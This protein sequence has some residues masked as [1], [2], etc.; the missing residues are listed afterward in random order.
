MNKVI[1]INDKIKPFNKTINIDGDKSLSIRFAILASL[2]EGKSRAFNLLKSED[3][4]NTLNCLKKLGA[5]TSLLLKH[6]ERRNIHL[7]E[8]L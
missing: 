4:L 6:Q 3:V 7:K 8:E 2:A 1:R 5:A